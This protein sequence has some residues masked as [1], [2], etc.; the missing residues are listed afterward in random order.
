M[1]PIESENLN[2]ALATMAVDA[3]V[4]L[5]TSTVRAVAG[6]FFAF[7]ALHVAYHLENPLTQNVGQYLQ[8][9]A[10]FVPVVVALV[11]LLLRWPRSSKHSTREAHRQGFDL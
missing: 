2:L 9:V 11:I 10:P 1:I 4:R 8:V 5:D 7:S 3:F 6:G